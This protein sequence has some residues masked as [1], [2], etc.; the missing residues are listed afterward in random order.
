MCDQKQDSENQ[1]M[2]A[3]TNSTLP[4]IINAFCIG[5]VGLCCHPGPQA[6]SL[7]KL[8]SSVYWLCPWTSAPQVAKRGRRP[9]SLCVSFDEGKT[10]LSLILQM[11]AC[12]WGRVRS[13][14]TL[15][16]YNR[17]R[18]ET[19]VQSRI[20]AKLPGCQALPT[21]LPTST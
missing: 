9:A 17:L 2:M 12:V 3:L 7:S 1:L 10:S 19:S 11:G 21:I 16:L 14:V 4:S 6:L 8:A 5:L 20:A 15:G 18:K 13:L